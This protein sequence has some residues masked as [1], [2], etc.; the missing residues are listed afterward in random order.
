MNRRIR[1]KRILFE[2]V[3]T[4]GT[5]LDQVLKI[6][7]EQNDEIIELRSIVERN[8]QAT[9]SRFHKFEKQV[10]NK[11]AKKSWFSKK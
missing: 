2:Y 11:N 5:V 3:N 9:N 4:L 10:A 7:N 1:K 6:I 8:A